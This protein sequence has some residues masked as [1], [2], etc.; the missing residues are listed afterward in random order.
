MEGELADLNLAFDK[1]RSQTNISD[2]KNQVTIIR[3]RNELLSQE[4]DQ[5]FTNRKSV[6]RKIQE[7]SDL[8]AS[9]DNE[10][11]QRLLATAPDKAQE[12]SALRNRHETLQNSLP[13]LKANL[14]QLRSSLNAAE[15]RLKNDPVRAKLE[16][17]AKTKVKLVEERQRLLKEAERASLTPAEQRDLLAAQIKSD[18]EILAKLEAETGAKRKASEAVRQRIPEIEKELS[19][20]HETSEEYTKLE[21]LLKKDKE[22][23]EF[24]KDFDKNKAKA[25]ADQQNAQAKI[26]QNLDI[27]SRNL[28]SAELAGEL[29]EEA[30]LAQIGDSVVLLRQEI[31]KRRAELQKLE[32]LN[33]AKEIA[34]LKRELEEKKDEM[35]NK[36]SRADEFI[37]EQE[38]E[39]ENLVNERIAS[40]KT[41]SIAL[42]DAARAQ[43]AVDGIRKKA[44]S[45]PNYKKA[46]E[47]LAKL[48]AQQEKVYK[49]K[50]ELFRR[51]AEIDYSVLKSEV[52]ALTDSINQS[53]VR[54]LTSN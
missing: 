23:E 47:D 29:A 5:V 30:S 34:E 7:I 14:A 1:F 50:E 21:I 20:N 15:Q 31:S 28:Q 24:L 41:L 2:I 38:R 10:L 53:L 43:S 37:R 17:L 22:M 19:G 9:I 52:M 32:A 11:Q 45:N 8:T 44:E 27:L 46:K 25:V 6:E 35:T 49:L 36:F 4:I 16:S 3:A 12:I 42:Q 39:I 26:L 48:A 54:Q 13:E 51:T 40:E 33:P 18:T